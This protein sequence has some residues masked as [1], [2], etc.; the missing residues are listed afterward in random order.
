ME[1]WNVQKIILSVLMLSFGVTCIEPCTRAVIICNN[2]QRGGYQRPLLLPISYHAQTMNCSCFYDNVLM[3]GFTLI[4]NL[5]PRTDV[6]RNLLAIDLRL[7]FQIACDGLQQ[8]F[9]HA[10]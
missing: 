6:A 5:K 3:I 9:H 10:E 1:S 4:L 8:K 2:K 7:D